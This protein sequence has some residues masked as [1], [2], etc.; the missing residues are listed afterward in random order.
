MGHIDDYN[1]LERKHDIADSVCIC[2]FFV[3]KL[4]QEADTILRRTNIKRLP[5]AGAAHDVDFDHLKIPRL[6]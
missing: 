1:I 4:K 6:G 3:H 5:F 2:I